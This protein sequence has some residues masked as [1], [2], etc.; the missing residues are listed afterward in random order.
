MRLRIAKTIAAA[1]VLC[2]GIAQ[3]ARAQ[4]VA[5]NPMEWMALAEGNESI[6]GEIEKEIKGQTKTPTKERQLRG[7]RALKM[8]HCYRHI[9]STQKAISAYRNALRYNVATLDDRLDYARLLLKNGEYKRAL[10][11]FELL[12][13]SMPNNVLVRNGLLSAKMAPKWKEQGSDYTVK[14]MTEFNSR[15][16][17][18]CPVLAGDQWD[19]LYFSSTRNDALGDELSGITGA[20]PGDIFIV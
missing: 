19:R 1:I 20:K 9:S 6:N 4:L 12:N 7:Q 10:A 18:Y 14:K 17:D 13:D 15:R 5:S 11:E 2:I 3:E 16:A 8:A